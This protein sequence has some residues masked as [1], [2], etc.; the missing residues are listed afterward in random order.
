[1]RTDRLIDEILRSAQI[2]S[3]SRRRE[4]MR[5]LRAH[6]EDFVVCARRA[7]HTEEEAERLA[8]ANFG[9]PRQIAAQFGWVYRKQRAAVQ[10]SVFVASALVV[11]AAST[12]IAMLLQAGLAFGLGRPMPNIF[13]SHHA[14]IEAADILASATAYLGLIALEKLLEGR[15]FV[16]AAAALSAI[17]AVLVTL[18]LLAG[19]P[20]LIPVFGLVIALFL[21]SVQRL[22]KS[23]AAR[24]GVVLACFGLFGTV[25]FGLLSVTSWLAV[26]TGYLVMTYLAA[27]VDRALFRRLYL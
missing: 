1:M 2:P 16:R 18:F 14:L 20:W 5:E 21:R 22:L 8:I 25:R 24:T 10:A 27:R 19:A 11:A 4:V 13:Y 6:V 3:E 9:N 12:G 15:N 23:P 26:G 17:F 7:G